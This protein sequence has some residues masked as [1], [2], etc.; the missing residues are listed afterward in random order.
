MHARIL[1]RIELLNKALLLQG[2]YIP[3]FMKIGP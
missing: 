1:L 3:N 2:S